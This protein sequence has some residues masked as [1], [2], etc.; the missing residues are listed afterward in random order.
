[1]QL[2]ELNRMGMQLYQEGKFQEAIVVFEQALTIAPLFAFYEG[3]WTLGV[4]ME[5]RQQVLA[6]V[7]VLTKDIC[8]PEATMHVCKIMA[9]S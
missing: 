3:L 5:L 6:N 7:A 2:A 8:T 9:S 4:N 1:M